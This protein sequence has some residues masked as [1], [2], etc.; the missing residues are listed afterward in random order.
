M[1]FALPPRKTSH[2]PPYARKTSSNALAQ[3]RRKLLQVVGCTVLAIITFF[4]TLSHLLSSGTRQ[5]DDGP[6]AIEGRQ[7]VV[8]V[9]VLDNATMSEEYVRMIKANRDHYAA[10]HGTQ[11]ARQDQR[12]ILDLTC[13]TRLSEFLHQH[14][15]L[16]GPRRTLSLLLVT[17]T[18]STPCFNRVSKDYVLMVAVRRRLDHR[19][20]VVSGRTHFT[21][22]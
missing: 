5:T 6:S 15:G 21:S 13:D 10:L 19:S 18:S 22:S 12:K 20:C 1:H 17:H 8:L 9:T 16:C 2:P 4:I 11:L 3:R 7:D 14:V